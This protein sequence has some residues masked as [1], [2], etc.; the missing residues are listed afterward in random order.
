MNPNGTNQHNCECNANNVTNIQ[1]RVNCKETICYINI[2]IPSQCFQ[3]QSTHSAIPNE[4]DSVT[5]IINA[6]YPNGEPIIKKVP[7]FESCND[8]KLKDIQNLCTHI[9]KPSQDF[10]SQRTQGKIGCL[11][12]YNID[13]IVPHGN[14]E[15]IVYTPAFKK[16]W[17]DYMSSRRYELKKNV[18]HIF[19]TFD[20]S[21]G[22]DKNFFSLLSAIFVDDQCI[23]LGGECMDFCGMSFTLSLSLSL[24]I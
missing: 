4:R 19:I 13:I 2:T 8:C 5:D 18:N 21:A 14:D 10:Q 15:S 22:K 3:C 11:V 12:N 7:W 1:R 23:I 24:L 16:E 20:P 6:K 17:I 9:T